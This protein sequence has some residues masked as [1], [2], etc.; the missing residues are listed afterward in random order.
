MKNVLW[1]VPILF[2][3]TACTSSKKYLELNSEK[4]QLDRQNAQLKRQINSLQDL[5]KQ[6]TTQVSVLKKDSLTLTQH[7]DSLVQII[8]QY[9]QT[10][11]L[12]NQQIAQ[13][14]QE[15]KAKDVKL[16]QKD[17]NID[18]QSTKVTQLRYSLNKQKKRIKNLRQNMTKAL[19]TFK[20]KDLK[21]SMKQS[22]VYVSLSNQ[23][24]FQS[25]STEIDQKGIKAI[26]ELAIVLNKNTDFDIRIEGHTDNAGVLEGSLY[27]DN[28][29]LSVLRA[30]A[31]VRLLV[32]N[33]VNPKRIIASG[34]GEHKPL[35]LNN[36]PENK[37]KNRR[38]EV[39]L[40]PK[41]DILA[42]ILGK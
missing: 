12:Q 28:W 3:M 20:S 27:K 37:S 15:V 17:T 38:I 42:Q 26:Q 35:V 24:L 36:S 32:K 10:N 39:I 33:K 7:Q 40:S 21:V 29:E 11:K 25:G 4:K 18:E 16:A 8:S 30:S 31:I 14:R 13:L 6:T 41:V 5:T 1:I 34:Q 22:K 19:E 23:L 2:L 9:E